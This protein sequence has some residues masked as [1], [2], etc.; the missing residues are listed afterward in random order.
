MITQYEQCYRVNSIHEKN[1]IAIQLIF[2][3]PYYM[4]IS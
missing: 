1:S 3:A 4:D 2:D